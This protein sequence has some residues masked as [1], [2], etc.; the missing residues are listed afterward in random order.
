MPAT[1]AIRSTLTQHRELLDARVKHD[2]IVVIK[3]V[4]G[5]VSE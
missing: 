4:Q 2:P 1:W 3:H 5:K